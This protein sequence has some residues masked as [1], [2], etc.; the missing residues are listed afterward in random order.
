MTELFEALGCA[1]TF[2]QSLRAIRK[3]FRSRSINLRDG[4]CDQM[5][6]MLVEH[7]EVH[8]RSGL[9]RPDFGDKF[10]AYWRTELVAHGRGG[11]RQLG[12][13][14]ARIL[15]DTFTSSERS[16]RAYLLQATAM[17]LDGDFAAAWSAGDTA[18]REHGRGGLGG[19]ALAWQGVAAREQNDL[20]LARSQFDL[21]AECDLGPITRSALWSSLLIS[22]QLGDRVGVVRSSD[23]LAEY[24][25]LLQATAGDCLLEMLSR[26]MSEPLFDAMLDTALELLESPRVLPE[27]QPPTSN[28]C[29]TSCTV[30]LSWR[31]SRAW[32]SRMGH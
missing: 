13:R 6:A 22:A 16:Q 24:T 18:V 2:A 23:R 28:E 25:T 11:I 4:A 32:S 9:Y 30:L 10:R 21:A 17:V 27:M 15:C 26:R 20:L 31:H 12:A 5:N 19:A 29:R 3:Q 7:L 1:P 8:P 14:E